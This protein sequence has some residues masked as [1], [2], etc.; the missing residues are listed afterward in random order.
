MGFTE[1]KGIREMGIICGGG[2]LV[3]LIPMLTLLPVL[4]LRG[5]RT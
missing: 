4:L 3:C 2:L 5:R 1:F